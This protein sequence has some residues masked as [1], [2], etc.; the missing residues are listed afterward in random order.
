V[1]GVVLAV[2]LVCLFPGDCSASE[3]GALSNK[4]VDGYIT[5]LGG[6]PSVGAQVRVEIWGG[7]WPVQSFFRTSQSDITD[8]SGH[9]EVTINGN[10]WDPHNTI[11]VFANDGVYQGDRKVE[12]NGDDFQT[13]NVTLGRLIPEFGSPMVIVAIS[14]LVVLLSCGRVARS[15]KDQ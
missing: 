13:V 6:Q 1:S 10:Y 7:A 8:S 12:A 9:Y 15:R 5:E 4:I 11:W 3:P 14:V 2:T